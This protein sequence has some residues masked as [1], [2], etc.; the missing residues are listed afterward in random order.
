MARKTHFA[1]FITLVSAVSVAFASAEFSGVNA[2]EGGNASIAAETGIE[3]AETLPATGQISPVFVAREVVQPLPAEPEAPEP[4]QASSLRQLVSATDTSGSLSREMRCLAG[5]VYFEARGEPLTGQLAV[6]QVVINRAESSRFPS[7]YC[8]VVH[9]R[10]QFSFVRGG[11]MPRINEA[12]AAWN[13]AKAIARIAHTGQWD[14]EA[15]DALY[16]HATYVSPQW[17][18]NKIRRA[19]I[20]THIFYR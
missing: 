20:N 6:A 18:R 10:S 5:T 8:G 4:V 15:A 14:S 9:Q 17:S 1:G 19:A 16:F 13:R 12:S 11:S 3:P 2:E 7:S